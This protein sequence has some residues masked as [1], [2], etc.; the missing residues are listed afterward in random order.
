SAP[1]PT[2]A[3]LPSSTVC[4]ASAGVCD[5]AESCTGTGAAC[6]TNAFL[7]SS[8]VCRAS[9]G[10]CD[11]VESCTGSSAS[12]PSDTLV[13]GPTLTPTSTGAEGA[14]APVSNTVL[15]AGVHNF[16]TI[17]IPAGVTVTTSGTGLL[18][19]RATGSI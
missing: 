5:T 3:F 14:F 6:P 19:L 1:C 4:R 16:T 17:N 12:C 18:D 8:T 11:V 7:P 10:G 2:D 9:A 15:A 13:S